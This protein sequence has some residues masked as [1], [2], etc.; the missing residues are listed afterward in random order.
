VCLDL[1]RSRLDVASVKGINNFIFILINSQLTSKA[2]QKYF[3]KIEILRIKFIEV[4]HII[5]NAECNKTHCIVSRP[6]KDNNNDIIQSQTFLLSKNLGKIR[7]TAI[8]ESRE[9]E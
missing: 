5:S 4:F 6:K 8:E 1:C 3:T 2:S 9:E 7:R